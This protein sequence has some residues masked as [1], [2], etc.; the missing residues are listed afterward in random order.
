METKKRTIGKLLIAIL[1]KDL[2]NI[3]IAYI[4][5]P[6]AIKK[7]TRDMITADDYFY[8]MDP[9]EMLFANAKLYFRHH[10]DYFYDTYDFI[11][12]KTMRVSFNVEEYPMNCLSKLINP[13]DKVTHDG[14]YFHL[15]DVKYQ[16]ILNLTDDESPLLI[17]RHLLA[18]CS[19]HD[20]LTDIYR[21][22]E[23][24][25]LDISQEFSEKFSDRELCGSD[26]HY[27]YIYDYSTV[28]IFDALTTELLDLIPCSM[29]CNIRIFIH[30]GAIM[31]LPINKQ[32]KGVVLI[33][34]E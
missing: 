18:F 27:I 17:G 24:K 30:S 6:I 8:D 29:D 3:C 2:A 21:L 12:D 10:G 23:Q 33:T 26:V 13:Q 15:N 4:P 14:D 34:I 9:E 19:Y 16:D 7:S 1:P 5:G 22:P 31:L 32:G 11:I 28:Y 25:K 20:D